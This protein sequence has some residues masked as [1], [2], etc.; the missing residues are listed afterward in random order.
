M[1]YDFSNLKKHIEDTKA[2]LK[3]EYVSI[4][5]GRAAPALLDN[6]KVDAYGSKL[7]IN[8]V[9]NVT[10]EDAR[11]LRVLPW[12]PSQVKEIES[13]IMT[14]DLGVSATSDE[15]GVRVS[16][17]ELTA[18]RRDQ[19]VKLVSDRLEKARISI[20]NERDEVRS[21]IQKKE[22]SSEISEDEKYKYMEELQKLV[23]AANKELEEMAERKEKD[24]QN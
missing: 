14:A 15:K 9:G 21:D 7:P 1:A 10:V 12:D 6:V 4:R 3:D 8:Q 2:W 18:E 13:A 24:V 5:T 11:T 20:R 22:K 17:P 16:F 23:D 19:L